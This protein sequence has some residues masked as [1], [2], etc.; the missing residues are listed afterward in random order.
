[1]AIFLFVWFLTFICLSV[2]IVKKLKESFEKRGMMNN[3]KTVHG[4]LCNSITLTRRES[5]A[6]ATG[7][8]VDSSGN[9]YDHYGYHTYNK[10]IGFMLKFAPGITKDQLMVCEPK[11]TDLMDVYSLNK[12]Q[13]DPCPYLVKPFSEIG[14]LSYVTDKNGKNYFVGFTPDA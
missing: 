11:L 2:F 5:R 9:M 14:T 3:I 13:Q 1:M 12:N 8:S 7:F 4:Y 10:P 6:E